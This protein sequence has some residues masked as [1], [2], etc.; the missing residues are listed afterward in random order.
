MAW[1]QCVDELSAIRQW[2]SLVREMTRVLWLAAGA[3]CPESGY[4]NFVMTKVDGGLS[5]VV[6]TWQRHS[7]SCWHCVTR[8]KCLAQTHISLHVSLS[9]SICFDKNVHTLADHNVLVPDENSLFLMY[10]KQ[11][12]KEEYQCP[13]SV[14]NMSFSETLMLVIMRLK[15][16]LE[17]CLVRDKSV[18]INDP[19]IPLCAPS[20]DELEMREHNTWCPQ[21]TLSIPVPALCRP[22]IMV[23]IFQT[24]TGSPSNL[25]KFK[26]ARTESRIVYL[27]SL[28]LIQ[29]WY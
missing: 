3:W 23:P 28:Q 8:D 7:V 26:V 10:T 5:Q 17:N 15:L 9:F 11:Y 1:V 29:L 24:G 19:N 14:W 21:N 13:S 18:I 6:D 12:D 16:F 27:S 22:L 20:W 2:F 25:L 4:R